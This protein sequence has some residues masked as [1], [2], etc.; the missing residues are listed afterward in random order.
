MN[1]IA[2]IIIL[3]YSLLGR[4]IKGK[5][6]NLLSVFA[7]FYGV[8]FFLANLRLYG[9]NGA[10]DQAATIILVGMTAYMCG[11]LFITA[12]K[13]NTGKGIRARINA[14]PRRISTSYQI[15]KVVLNIVIVFILVYS[16]YRLFMLLRLLGSGLSYREIR[17]FYFNS[18]HLSSSLAASDFGKSRLDYYLV[19]PLLLCVTIISCI[20][21]FSD[22]L[23]DN[24]KDRIKLLSIAFICTL[25]S[26]VS[27]GSRETMLYYVLMY[28][29]AFFV[30]RKQKYAMKAQISYS[31][32]K[33]QKRFVF[34]IVFVIVA[35]LIIIT[36]SRG[37]SGSGIQSLFRTIY[38]YFTGYIPNMSVWL[39][40]VSAADNTYGY[41]FV[42]GLVRVP[43]GIIHSLFGIPESHA[44][45]VAEMLTNTLQKRV[46]IGQ[47]ITFNAYVSL[48]YYFFRDF[49]YASL[50][51]ESLLFGIVCGR[52]EMKLNEEPTYLDLFFYF[53][54]FYLVVASMVR[55]ELVHTRTAMALFY[56]FLLLRK[57][58]RKSYGLDMQSAMRIGSSG[59]GD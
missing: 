10:S 20:S 22:L 52:Q 35:A 33:K 17:Y 8:T 41:A 48:F 29:F 1:W 34:R 37:Q 43:V 24:I 36:F 39:E 3:S 26:S 44:Y 15:N 55:W 6:S 21:F 27:S 57:P 50:I 58:K 30:F 54:C 53:L 42:L 2:A 32:S 5:W 46:E 47:G 4:A 13:Q 12:Y 16:V 23:Y 45:S 11:Y 59:K 14:A 25:M 38:L 7:G 40:E 18:Q 56:V 31:L 19:E 28:V 51:I 49:G 9:L